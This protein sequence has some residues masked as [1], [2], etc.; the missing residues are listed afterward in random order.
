MYALQSW[1]RNQKPSFQTQSCIY[2]MSILKSIIHWT[3][4]DQTHN[5]P[6]RQNNQELSRATFIHIPSAVIINTSHHTCYQK[7]SHRNRICLVQ[8][9]IAYA[10]IH[11]PY[12]VSVSCIVSQFPMSSIDEVS[13]SIIDRTAFH[14]WIAKDSSVLKG[15]PS[16]STRVTIVQN[17][18]ANLPS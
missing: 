4:D 1:N 7:S 15:Q 18:W 10:E 6:C 9:F 16:S 17:S 11:M 13:Q 2:H 12:W 5:M 14:V 3:E 8:V